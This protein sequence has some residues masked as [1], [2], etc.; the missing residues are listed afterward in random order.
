MKKFQKTYFRQ[1]FDKMDTN[2][3]GFIEAHD[4][5]RTLR[6]YASEEEIQR[7]VSLDDINGD[8]KVSF[9][10]FCHAMEQTQG[11]RENDFLLE[12]GTVDWLAVFEHYDSDGSGFLERE[13]LRDFFVERGSMSE[14]E[15]DALIEEMD[16]VEKDGKISFAEL[17]LYHMN[18]E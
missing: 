17:V 6:A 16:V 12:D 11:E 13:E 9:D 14:S 7:L 15:L 3:S 5:R 8:G 2:R 18:E 10:E 1:L 4:Y